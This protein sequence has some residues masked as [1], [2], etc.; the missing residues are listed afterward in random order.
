M[1]TASEAKSSSYYVVA[2][3]LDGSEQRLASLSTKSY[4]ITFA[5]I[6]R[7]VDVTLKRVDVCH[8]PSS[9]I[10]AGWDRSSN[11]GKWTRT[12]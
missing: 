8:S 10:L 9:R 3:K 7:R 2:T 4:A 11:T 6:L 1:E 12:V 5:S